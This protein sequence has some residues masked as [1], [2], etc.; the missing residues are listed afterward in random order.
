[1]VREG[2]LR[3]HS[4]LPNLSLEPRDMLCYAIVR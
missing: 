2:V 1:M 4:V 3:K